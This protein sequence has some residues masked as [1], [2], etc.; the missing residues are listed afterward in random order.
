MLCKSRL[1][2]Y[3]APQTYSSHI[4]LISE[5]DKRVGGEKRQKRA[6]L[7]L[8]QS[9]RCLVTLFAVIPVNAH[10]SQAQGQRAEAAGKTRTTEPGAPNPRS[11]TCL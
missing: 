1:S 6:F 4:E 5:R 8:R 10:R 11:R 7:R 3:C 2:I 9:W